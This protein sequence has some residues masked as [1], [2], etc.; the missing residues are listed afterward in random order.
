MASAA[1]PGLGGERGEEIVRRL[2]LVERLDQRLHQRDGAVERSR[3]PPAFERMCLRDVPVAERR[4]LVN[5]RRVIDDERDFD[6]AL[7]EAQVHG[8][9]ERRIAAH[10]HE[11]FDLPGLDGLRE[12]GDCGRP[13]GRRGLDAR[14]VEDRRPGV[15]ERVVDRL[16]RRV[17]GVGLE[18]ARDHHRPPLVRLEVLRDRRN[19]LGNLRRTRHARRRRRC[20]GAAGHGRRELTRD[21]LDLRRANRESMIRLG[22]GERRR[23]LDGVEPVHR[24]VFLGQTPAAGE[25]LRIPDAPGS[26]RQEIGVER[27]DHVGFVELVDRARLARAAARPRDRVV[28]VPLRAGVVAQDFPQQRGERGRRNRRRQEMNAG[29]GTS[30]LVAQRLLH[31]ADEPR[32]SPHLAAEVDRLCPIGVVEIEDRGLRQDV[33]AAE[34]CR[35]LW[36]ALDFGRP[37]HMAF[38]QN[39]HGRAAERNRAGEVERPSRNDFLRLPDVRDDGFGG[40]FGAGA[41]TRQRQRGAHQLEEVAASFRVVPFRGLIRELPVQVVAEFRRVGQLAEAAPIEAAVGAGETGFDGGKVH[42]S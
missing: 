14:A 18:F 31:G 23:A 37:P 40:L 22:A 26:A 7:G 4:G 5:V 27:H 3:I 33:G 13:P 20:R 16:G 15:A 17:H 25:I 29:A 30:L 24:G 12:I 38:D 36:V 1:T 6:E 2:T 39:R 35:M 8:S 11:Q 10:D 41:H 28:L 42:I 19:P 21:A 32:P 34:A 9:G